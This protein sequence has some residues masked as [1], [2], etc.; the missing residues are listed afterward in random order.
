MFFEIWGNRELWQ[1]HMNNENLK[2]YMDATDGAVENLTLNKMSQICA[3]NPG[4][5]PKS[6]KNRLTLLKQKLRSD[7][8]KVKQKR[9]NVLLMRF[10]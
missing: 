4:I 8:E 3:K 6:A 10:V 1:V 2:A 7:H 5:V 9:V